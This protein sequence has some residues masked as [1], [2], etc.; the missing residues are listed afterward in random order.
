M[1]AQRIVNK[2]ID[3]LGGLTGIV[4]DANSNR[5]LAGATVVVQGTSKNA[6]TDNDGKFIFSLLHADT[7]TITVSYVGFD[8]KQISGVIVKA[9]EVTTLSITLDAA[10]SNL[11]TVIVKTEAR[12]ENIAAVLNTR[13]NA[14]VV[15]DVI[16]ADM[17]KRSPDRSTSD[18][19]KRV[20]GTTIQDNKFVVVRGMND[21]YN[22][23]MLNGALMPSSEPDRKT[24][25]FDIFPADLIDNI[26]VIKSATPELPGSFSGG[27]IQINTKDVPDKK[28]WGFK[29]G[30]G[31]NS[32]ATGHDIYTYK[33][34]NKDWIGVDDNTRALS[35]YFPSVDKYNDL[36]DIQKASASRLLS[37][38]WGYYKMNGPLNASIQTSGGFAVKLSRKKDYPVL[39]A[40]IGA[41]YS[42]TY[43][44]NQYRRLAYSPTTLDTAANITDSTT[45]RTVLASTMVNAT[46]KLNPA[47]K[48]FFNNIYSVNSSDKTIFR[49]G[50][51]QDQSWYDTRSNS[52]YFTSN[53]I[54]NGQMGG[55]HNITINKSKWRIKWLAYYTTLYRNQPDYRRNLYFKNDPNQPFSALITSTPS[56]STNAGVHYFGK[57]HDNAE[58]FNLDL[59]TPFKWL[60]NTQ[61]FKFG[62]SVY[63][64]ARDLQARFLSAGIANS[65]HF[66]YNLLT[67][68]QDSIFRPENFNR[69]K[70][71]ILREDPRRLLY[72]YSGS[73]NTTALYAMMDNRVTKNFRITWG[74]RFEKYR[75]IIHTVDANYNNLTID[76]VYN[77]FLPSANFVYSVLPKANLRFSFS[78]TVARPQY[79][80]LANILFFDYD[81]NVTIAGN[82]YLTETHVNNYDVRWEHY[83]P[84]AQYYSA[85]V[86]YKKFDNAIEQYLPFQGGDSRTVGFQNVKDAYNVGIELEGRKNFDFIDQ[87]LESLVMYFNFAY[88]KSVVNQYYD[89]VL[90]QRPLQGQSPYVFNVSLLYND[91]ASKIGFSLLYNAIGPRIYLIGGSKDL[92]IWEKPHGLLDFKIQRPVL[93][94]KG[95]IEL[96][97]SDILHNNDYQYWNIANNNKS[98]NF[99]RVKTP[100][101]QQKN[102]GFNV[103]LAASFK[104]Y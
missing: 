100:M 92:N 64:D 80:E 9:G 72:G 54:Y 1:P 16:S 86:F 36:K 60:G 23:A 82:P 62:G 8:T 94:E 39:A 73:I 74:L 75:N 19:L 96:T 28:F 53:L 99:D 76:T 31:L 69:V 48:F 67:W 41:T 47:N 71:F 45:N 4:S 11:K 26:T 10:K 52:F 88:I 66:N 91:P 103:T 32:L 83:F 70:G 90:N 51:I 89:T 5:K 14:A 84:Q 57:L 22:E 46:L 21:R 44:F 87:K 17:I 38:N 29:G 61:T 95:L 7:I 77:D 104:I 58:G 12:R 65:D 35:R 43:R 6:Q 81:D 93:K 27:L 40:V 30:L 15:S 3:Q 50:P 59:S 37:K 97:F 55:D 34:G 79:R 49:T 98:T 13:R 24:F 63:H 101:I 56:V 68:G 18:V 42:S 85:S 33:G 2:N 25:A 102:F 78:R 20:S